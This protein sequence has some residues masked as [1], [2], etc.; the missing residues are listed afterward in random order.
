MKRILFIFTVSFVIVFNCFGQKL[1]LADL[2]NICNNNNWENIN[3]TLLAKGWI[4]EDSKNDATYDLSAIVWSF[5][6]NYYNDKA[7]AWF[8]VYVHKDVPQ[9]II[10]NI[11]NK[12]SYT[13]VQ[14]SINSSGFKL[15][16]SKIEDNKIISKYANSKYF[17]EITTQK[18]E[19]S[20]SYTS[21][22]EYDIILT[23]KAGFYDSDNGKKTEYY[24]NGNV[25]IEYTLL[26]GEIHGEFKVYYNDGKFKRIGHYS[27]GVENGL[28]KEYYKNGNIEKEYSML[29]GKLNGI[30]KTYYSNGQLS[31]TGSYSNELENGLFK[32]Y[33]E[34]GNIISEYS[35]LNGE[36]NG[37]VKL[38]HSN[39]KLKN[40]GNFTN[41]IE[42]GLFREYDNNGKLIV[43]RTMLNGKKNGVVKIFKNSYDYTLITFKND[44][45]NGLYI[46]YYYI[47]TD[48]YNL[49][50]G[51]YLDGEKHGTW[52]IIYKEKDSLEIVV[53]FE[54]YEKGIKNGEFRQIKGDSLVLGS[55]KNDK[56]HGEYKIYRLI[57]LNPFFKS[58][59]N[60]RG[61][62][63]LIAEGSYYDGL[64]SDYWKNYEGLER[65]ISEGMFLNGEKT[66]EWKYYCYTD[67]DVQH[68]EI[69]QNY[70]NG[71]LEGKSIRYLYLEEIKYPCS[72]DD[73]RNNS[74]DTCV[75]YVYEKVLE[76]A[77]YKDGKRNGTFELRDSTNDIVS[78]GYF[79]DGL[80]DGEWVIRHD[81]EDANG[82]MSFFY[83]KGSYVKDKKNG[84]WIL[85]DVNGTTIITYTYKNG[86]FDGELIVWKNSKPKSK[87]I[88]SN[89]KLKEVYEYDSTG[90]K[91]DIKYVIY[92]ETPLSCTCKEIVYYTDNTSISQ[93]YWIKKEKSNCEEFEYDL[94]ILKYT[95]NDKY[96][97]GEFKYLD[98]NQR[99][100]IVGKHDGEKMIGLWTFFYYDQNVKIEFNYI[101]NEQVDEKYLTLNGDLFS[102][103]FVY[104]DYEDQI[105]EKRKI[106][107]GLR[108]GKTVY[109]NMKTNKIIKREKY[110]DGKLQ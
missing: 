23:K 7:Q 3:Q 22:T 107:D 11:F 75:E 51:E 46:D 66:G 49:R 63:V 34:N 90:I 85:Y 98:S 94:D 79:K 47:D 69:V 92:N 86:K 59:S 78:K 97:D 99:P 17:L 68:L 38:Y 14:N 73:N 61:I 20:Q 9:K 24:A 6:K 60:L 18:R 54:N 57:E 106:K 71:K 53:T 28:F 15:I 110:K 42:N 58:I 105:K 56:L 89:G 84:K 76:T 31:R 44:T 12:E 4:Y 1:T 5:K 77:F 100:I 29:K 96:R 88:Y 82:E 67:D 21:I 91:P 50:K 30:F 74:K 36:Y 43:E 13:I 41:G 48:S 102:G 93:E 70:L 81:E 2:V 27:N 65:L 52:Q 39:G 32:E 62:Q 104:Y 108:N 101:N 40:I 33:D 55:Y 35:K 83:E 45:L 72:D 95:S 25:E 10:Y 8:Y 19:E 87:L 103:N 26:D 109:I 64:K 16:K 37:T 80:K